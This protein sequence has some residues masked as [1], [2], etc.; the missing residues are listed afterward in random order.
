M[1]STCRLP[2]LIIAGVHKAGTTSLFVYLSRHPEICASRVKETGF[3]MPLRDGKE[4]PPEEVYQSY[5]AHCSDERYVVEASPSYL[6][7]KDAIASALQRTCGKPK[8][9]M[10]LREPVDRLQSFYH[11]IVSKSMLKEPGEI[12]AFVRKSLEQLRHE[13]EHDYFSRGVR[14]GCY[15]EFLDPWFDRYGDDLRIVF[16]DDLR[17]NPKQLMQSLWHWL[18]LDPPVEEKG[19]YSIE[20]KTVYVKN[21]HLHRLLLQTNKRMEHFWRR[22][23]GLKKRLR[24]W[25]Y[26]FNA[27]EAKNEGMDPDLEAELRDFYKPYNLQLGRLLKEKGYKSLPSWV[28]SV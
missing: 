17:E 24:S 11:H 1:H 22:H 20:N 19:A 28:D 4:L 13:G 27:R 2:N 8:I 23:H 12:R 15:S 25:Y 10:I 9:V 3:F 26:L 16:F 14:E 7:G 21:Q 18:E 6:Y 5:F